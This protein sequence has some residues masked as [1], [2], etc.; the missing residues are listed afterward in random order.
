MKK[1]FIKIMVLN[2]ICLTLSIGAKAQHYESG[3]SENYEEEAIDQS[4]DYAMPINAIQGAAMM[5]QQS[6]SSSNYQQDE[7]THFSGTIAYP[8]INSTRSTDADNGNALGGIPDPP[9]DTPIDSNLYV[10][11]FAAIVYGFYQRKR[12]MKIAD[13]G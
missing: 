10:L 11:F 8:S 4:F 3:T 9:P 6:T 1:Q 12:L 7:Q 2:M 5:N 13:R